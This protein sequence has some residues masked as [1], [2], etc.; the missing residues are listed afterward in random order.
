MSTKPLIVPGWEVSGISSAEKFFLALPE[1]LPL[2]VNLC[3]EGTRI[4]PDALA[5]FASNAATY[6]LEIPTGTIWPKPSMFHVRATEQ[7]LRQLAALAEKRAEAEVCDHFHAYRDSQGLMRWYDA[8][9]GDPVLIEESIPEAKVQGFCR[10][11]GAKYA[12]WREP[13]SRK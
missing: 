10:K 2:P 4:S 1:I 12:R 5:L 3:F 13:I 7:F 9:S 11:L 8:F 6:T